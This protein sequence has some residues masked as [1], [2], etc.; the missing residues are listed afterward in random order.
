MKNCKECH[1]QYSQMNKNPEGGCTP[2]VLQINN[3]P[4]VVLFH[5]RDFP[6]SLGDDVANPPQYGAYKNTLLYYEA[7]GHS[8]LYDSDGIYTPLNLS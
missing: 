1:K 6:A 5:R 7:N 2:P 3:P 4:E 8:Y